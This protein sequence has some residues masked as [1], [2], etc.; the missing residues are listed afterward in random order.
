MKKA[1]T[2]KLIA[3]LKS[4]IERDLGT[5]EYIE[6]Q[7][8]KLNPQ[9]I[10]LQTECVARVSLSSSILRAIELGDYVDLVTFTKRTV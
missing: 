6:R 9:V 5:L 2:H 8:N 7:A 3:H 10:Q 1:D 4:Q